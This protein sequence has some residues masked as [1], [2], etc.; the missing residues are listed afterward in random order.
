[1][2]CDATTRLNLQVPR[3]KKS[4]DYV[5]SRSFLFKP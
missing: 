5:W 3:P 2:L 4:S 1:M